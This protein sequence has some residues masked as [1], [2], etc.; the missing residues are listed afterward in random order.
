MDHRRRYVHESRETFEKLGWVRQSI[1]Y[2]PLEIP[3]EGFDP[4]KRKPN[5]ASQ[6]NRNLWPPVTCAPKVCVLS[7]S[8]KNVSQDQIALLQKKCNASKIAGLFCVSSWN[9]SSL[10]ISL[11]PEFHEIA[12]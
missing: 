12:Q 2:E 10:I 8:Q 6:Y 11:M 1:L 7:I 9:F 4:V 3:T 5:P